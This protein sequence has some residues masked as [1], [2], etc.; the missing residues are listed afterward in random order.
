MTTQALEAY[1]RVPV[2]RSPTTSMSTTSLLSSFQV[3]VY[4]KE[5]DDVQR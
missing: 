3:F 1:Q 2:E 4:V 5:N